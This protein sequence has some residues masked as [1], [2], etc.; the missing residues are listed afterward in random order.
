MQSRPLS[1]TRTSIKVGFGQPGFDQDRSTQAAAVT[2]R[3]D[4]VAQ[5]IDQHLLDLQQ[6]DH[7]TRYI[8][9]DRG[10]GGDM[11][12]IEIGLAQFDVSSTIRSSLH[13]ARLLRSSRT[14]ARRWRTTSA[15]RST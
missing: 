6:V 9:R 10:P 12:A 2:D 5:E 11:H 4:R 8:G 1:T 15:A 3:F 13:G 14:S 7:D